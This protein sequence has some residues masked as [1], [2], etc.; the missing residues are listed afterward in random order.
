MS[1]G[2]KCLSRDGSVCL[3]H[4]SWVRALVKMPNLVRCKCVSCLNQCSTG[5]ISSAVA[6]PC[7]SRDW[8]HCDVHQAECCITHD[9]GFG[10]KSVLEQ[11]SR[12]TFVGGGCPLYRGNV[13]FWSGNAGGRR[14]ITGNRILR[15][16]RQSLEQ[17]LKTPGARRGLVKTAVAVP[18]RQ[19]CSNCSKLS[20]LQ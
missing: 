2:L 16:A 3:C 11:Q 8:L 14:S 1:K 10:Q 12:S 6:R 9:D 13:R 20:D 19:N 17:V 15:F 18:N 7:A 4:S 5:H